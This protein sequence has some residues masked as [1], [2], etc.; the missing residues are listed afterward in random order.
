MSSIKRTVEKL[1]DEKL[2]NIEISNCI[3]LLRYIYIGENIRSEG[4]L[5]TDNF[6]K[7]YK[8][9]SQILLKL[10]LIEEEKWYR[11]Y[12]YKVSP[13][14]RRTGSK[15]VGEKIEKE[16]EYIKRT[17]KLQPQ[18]LISFLVHEYI[19][20]E[21]AFEKEKVFIWDWKQLILRNTE[22]EK[23]RQILFSLLKN[24]DLC[25]ITR[26][27]VSTRGG[28]LREECYVISPE[29]REFLSELYPMKGLNQDDENYCKL[30]D[31][32]LTKLLYLSEGISTIEINEDELRLLGDIHVF[33]P[34]L[35]SMLEE[36]LEQL[37]IDSLQFDIR[38]TSIFT[39][40]HKSNI[41][42][43]LNFRIQQIING[44]LEIGI[45][46]KEE[47]DTEEKVD[48]SSLVQRLVMEKRNLYQMAAQFEG[49][50]IFKCS[51]ETEGCI[52]KLTNPSSEEVGLKRYIEDLHQYIEE[53]STDHIL[54][55]R[56]S[57]DFTTFQ[58][59]LPIDEIPEKAVELFEGTSEFFRDLNKLRNCYSAHLS[60]A[61]GIYEAGNIFNKLVGKRIPKDTDIVRTQKILLEKA[62]DSLYSLSR[63]LEIILRER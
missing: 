35:K 55:F 22:V 49:K 34:K 25:V 4:I 29:V 10:E 41:E 16:R 30:Y 15:L 7:E 18:K 6:I 42:A 31:L 20:K 45:P 12:L 13:Q 27:Y 44:L 60:D 51:P 40:V 36:L 33:Y 32:L 28:E 17:L 63:V 21:L 8:K 56:P 48:F 2:N 5:Q 53:S 14:A 62:I 26:S 54:K 1:K 19:N 50:D 58:Q 23:L 3:D 61:R 24:K 57:P 37:M 11:H 46:K 39:V 9:E 59:W 38:G 43:Y 52:V 47:K